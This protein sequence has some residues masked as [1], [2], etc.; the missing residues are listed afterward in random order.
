VNDTATAYK[1]PRWSAPVTIITVFFDE[2]CAKH[3]D[4]PVAA[5]DDGVDS[6]RRVLY[7]CELWSVA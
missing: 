2:T 1:G 4:A 3:P 5:T 7:V 6:T